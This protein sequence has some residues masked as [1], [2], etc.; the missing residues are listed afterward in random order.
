MSSSLAERNKG[1]DLFT[2]AKP[3]RPD[4]PSEKGLDCLTTILKHH[5]EPKKVVVA[6]RAIPFSPKD[7]SSWGNIAE[8]V[9]ELRRLS[10]HSQFGAY[11]E[12]ALR[13]RLACRCQRR[14]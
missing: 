11:L 5:Y 13:D 9:P 6:A 1:K 10:T 12:E 14:E 3:S 8:Y 2:T 4:K 7:P